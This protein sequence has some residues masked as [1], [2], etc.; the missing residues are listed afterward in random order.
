M[1]PTI[2]WEVVNYE[3]NKKISDCQRLRKGRVN[4]QNAMFSRIMKHFHD[5]KTVDLYPRKWNVL[6]QEQIVI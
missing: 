4:G 3:D 1:N 6:Y 5:V 2:C